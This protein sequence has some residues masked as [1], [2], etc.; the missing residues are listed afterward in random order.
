MNNQIKKAVEV[1]NKGGMIIFPT[2]TA[3]GI[4]CRIDNV[5][6]IERLF[7][8]R[9]RPKNQ[10]T[11]VLVS[12]IEMA[13]KYVTNIQKDVKLKLMDNYWPGAL[14][15]VLPAQV[16]KVPKLV[17]GGAENI[18]L[19]MPKNETILEIIKQVGV[20]ILG[21]SANLHGNKTPYEIK[22]LDPVLIDKIDLV[23]NGK[24]ELKDVSTVIDCSVN[25]WRILR[26]GAVKLKNLDLQNIVL[27][28]N[29][30]N[31]QEIELRLKYG[32]RVVFLKEL[33]KADKRDV[34]LNLIDKLLKQNGFTIY[35]LNE[36]KVN[37][38][39]GS[40]T[41]IRVGISIANTISA[42]LKIPVNGKKIGDLE[43]AVYN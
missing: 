40:F 37:V 29:T 13:N 17:R 34:V 41:G 32:E 1:L 26:D 18:G 2:D 31:N 20:P 39:P 22:D 11:P 12:N 9:K 33:L 35:D 23:V 36:V 6:A 43:N 28:I 3:F 42:L 10:A 5:G 4:G 16:S 7:E 15:I 8:I 21:P 25:P 19:R 24:C 38:G 27:Y 14:T 30:S